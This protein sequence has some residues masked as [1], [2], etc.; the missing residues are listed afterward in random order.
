MVVVEKAG[1]V[2]H[3]AVPYLVALLQQQAYLPCQLT[4]ILRLHQ[5]ET[6]LGEVAEMKSSV[7]TI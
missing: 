3:H 4:S 2:G 5:L 6:P 7:F 1:K